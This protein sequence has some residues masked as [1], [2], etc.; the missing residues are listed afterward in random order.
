MTP[1][2]RAARA[3]TDAHDAAYE[4]MLAVR[5]RVRRWFS[6]EAMASV[7]R[8]AP[9]VVGLHDS[10]SLRRSASDESR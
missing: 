9:E 7:D 5:P 2:T 4:R 8:D 10:A 6:P 1:P 3:T